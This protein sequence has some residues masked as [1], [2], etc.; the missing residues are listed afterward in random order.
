MRMI[1]PVA[2]TLCVAACGATEEAPLD[3]RVEA[4]AA[5]PASDAPGAEVPAEVGDGEEPGDG[6]DEAR[7]AAIREAEAF[8]RAQGYTDAPATVSGD[9]IVREGIEG[10]VEM[11]RNMLDPR[12]LGASGEGA[13]WSVTFRYASPERA[14]R[15]RMLLIHAGS[16]PRFVHQDLLLSAPEV[17]AP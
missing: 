7:R 9:D 13:D 1:L 17:S 10:T 16:P 15:G 14:G 3:E 2:V 4:A 6:A 11:R 12:A 5:E 8:V